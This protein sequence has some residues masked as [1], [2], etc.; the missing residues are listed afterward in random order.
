MTWQVHCRYNPGFITVSLWSR[1]ALEL[2]PQKGIGSDVVVMRWGGN[3]QYCLGE[4]LIR[5]LVWKLHL[6]FRFTISTFL[7]RLFDCGTPMRGAWHQEGNDGNYEGTNF[8]FFPSSYLFLFLYFL[9]FNYIYW[10]DIGWNFL[11]LLS[12][13]A[14]EMRAFFFFFFPLQLYRR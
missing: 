2:L 5:R 4:G 12:G 1:E 14:C 10:G 7:F 11:M 6:Y 13:T 8:F 9:I 3:L